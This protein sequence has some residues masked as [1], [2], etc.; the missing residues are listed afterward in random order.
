MDIQAQK[1]ELMQMLL[2]T[3]KPSIIKKIQAIFEEEGEIIGTDSNGLPLTADKLEKEITEAESDI[4]AGR[5]YSTS[6][7][8]NHFNL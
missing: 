6:Q 4:K 7:V 8:K 3:T 5:T 1:L 2:S